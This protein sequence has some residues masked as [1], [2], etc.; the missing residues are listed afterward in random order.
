MIRNN[1][2]KTNNGQ[3]TFHLGSVNYLLDI[4]LELLITWNKSVQDIVNYICDEDDIK[5]VSF[6]GSDIV[7]FRFLYFLL[8]IIFLQHITS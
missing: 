2:R 3:G 8:T 1:F 6:I 5:A 7:S 4:S